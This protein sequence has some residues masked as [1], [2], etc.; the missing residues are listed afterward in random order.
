MLVLIY[1]LAVGSSMIAAIIWYVNKRLSDN[2]DSVV[3]EL[4][5]IGGGQPGESDNPDGYSGI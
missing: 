1:V 4:E 3:Q 5:K 2:I